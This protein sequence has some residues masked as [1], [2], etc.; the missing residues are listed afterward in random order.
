MRSFSKISAYLQHDNGTVLV[1]P[2]NSPL[3]LQYPKVDA[4]RSFMMLGRHEATRPHHL[5]PE[6][7]C[8]QHYS[9]PDMR[10]DAE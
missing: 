1:P 6:P 5:I 2:R 7:G 10:S 9:S 4:Q 8:V 3:R